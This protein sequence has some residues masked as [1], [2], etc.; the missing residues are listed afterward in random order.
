MAFDA[1]N[2][3]EPTARTQDNRRGYRM[4][5]E[6]EENR[7]SSEGA[8]ARIMRGKVSAGRGEGQYYISKEG[9]KRQFRET[10]GFEPYPGTLNI[11]MESPLV[12]TEQ[13]AIRFKGFQDGDRTFGECRCY[14]IKLNGIEAALVRPERSDYPADLIEVIAPVNLRKALVLEDGDRVEVTLL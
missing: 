2:S 11:K 5:K 8:P 14:K 13:K 3:L 7:E 6:N 4:R 10:L 12:P 9:Y 1:G